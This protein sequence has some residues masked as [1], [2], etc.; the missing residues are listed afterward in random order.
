[1]TDCDNCPRH[2][3]IEARIDSLCNKLTLITEGQEKALIM[4]TRDMDRRLEDM[5]QFRAQ[6]TNQANTFA[7]RIELKAEAEKLDLKLAPLLS[8]STYREGS[9]KWTDHILTVLI[10]A[11]VM[12]VFKLLHV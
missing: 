3:G 10:A 11:A 8:M 6:L 2:S 7:T 4:A 12:L 5:N 9:M 1:M